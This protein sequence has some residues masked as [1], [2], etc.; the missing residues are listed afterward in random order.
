MGGE[1]RENNEGNH[2]KQ[3]GA[4]LA[5]HPS[6]SVYGHDGHRGAPSTGRVDTGPRL[7]H[8]PRS[9]EG[10]GPSGRIGERIHGLGRATACAAS[11][12]PALSISSTSTPQRAAVTE[13]RRAALLCRAAGVE[14][15]HHEEPQ[16]AQ[17][18]IAAVPHGTYV[19]C[20]A[21]PERDPIWQAMW[22][23]RPPIKDGMLEVTRDPGFGLILDAGM[24][25]RYRV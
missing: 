4:F 2:S 18:L 19:E 8:R 25:R 1:D 23:N 16:I 13:W 11:S 21:D 20:F 24:I 7:G 14:M 5:L 9:E 3:A 10:P 17:H 22:A 12:R 15:A 6:S